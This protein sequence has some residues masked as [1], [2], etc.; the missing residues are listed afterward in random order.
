MGSEAAAERV[1]ASISEWIERRLR[2]RVNRA[3]SGRGRP[4]ERQF[5]G[6]AIDREGRI[7]LAERSLQRYK[8]KVRELWRGR[9]ALTS[10]QLRDRWRSWLEGW[11]GYFRLAENRRRL[12]WLEGWT[13]RHIRKC[14]W[15][16]WHDT[17][18]RKNALRRL[19]V[20][21]RLLRVVATRRGSWFMA[22][23]AVMQQGLS[24]ARLKRH[25]FLVPSQLAA[26]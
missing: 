7:E 14:F 22:R 4:W 12:L 23:N 3:K 9:Q 24:N 1:E 19:G 13:R 15:L 26:R 25:G 17:A 8:R 11:W 16:K 18:G 5:L 10:T 20:S 6:F 2:L 21:E